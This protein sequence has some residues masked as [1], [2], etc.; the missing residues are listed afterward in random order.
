MQPARTGD[1]C[2]PAQAGDN[3]FTSTPL[4]NLVKYTVSDHSEIYTTINLVYLVPPVLG[5]HTWAFQLTQVYSTTQES[6]IYYTVSI[7]GC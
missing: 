7:I 2:Q 1:N 4:S 6:I 5:I 3:F